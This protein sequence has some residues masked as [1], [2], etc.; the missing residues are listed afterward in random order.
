MQVFGDSDEE[1]LPDSQVV[2]RT[3]RE[4]YVS[5]IERYLIWPYNIT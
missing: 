5:C 4:D 3:Q 1:D 2:G